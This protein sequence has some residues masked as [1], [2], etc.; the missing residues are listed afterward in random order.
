MTPANQRLAD[1]LAHRA[2]ALDR[3]RQAD[4]AFMAVACGPDREAVAAANVE[5][6]AALDAARGALDAVEEAVRCR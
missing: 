2:A 3:V 1:A 4:A 5:M 6:R